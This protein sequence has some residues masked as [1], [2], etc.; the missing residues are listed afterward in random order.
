MNSFPLEARV[1]R[2]SHVQVLMFCSG[3][4]EILH[5]FILNLWF[6]KQS[7][8]GLWHLCLSQCPAFLGLVLSYLLPLPWY[9]S[10][11]Q[12]SLPPLPS[13][14]GI[15]CPWQGLGRGGGGS[16]C[17]S[18]TK[19]YWEG[20]Q[21]PVRACMYHMSNLIPKQGQYSTA[22]KKHNDNLRQGL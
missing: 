9:P 22:N 10:H 13:D 12:A 7:Q 16:A 21:S 15:F 2:G 8:R 18:S 11:T 14:H 3:C 5:K 4:L 1:R 19:S 20:L 6:V 17:M